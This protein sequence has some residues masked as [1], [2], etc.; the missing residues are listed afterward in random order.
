MICRG[1][2]RIEQPEVF[3]PVVGA[4]VRQGLG[5]LIC[6]CGGT[7]SSRQRKAVIALIEGC[8]REA[9]WWL[10][11]YPANRV[12]GDCCSL[13]NKTPIGATFCQTHLPEDI[14]TRLLAGINL[15]ADRD[16][17]R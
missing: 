11:C 3:N 4:C 1:Q 8:L 17:E 6:R 16:C 14:Q 9:S 12:F 7:N 2:H 15:D 13:A 10:S 5:R